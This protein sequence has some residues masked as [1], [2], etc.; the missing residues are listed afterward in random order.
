MDVH[1]GVMLGH[2]YGTEGIVINK[3]LV[4]MKELGYDVIAY[5]DD[6]VVVSDVWEEWRY[7]DRVKSYWK[8]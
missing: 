3:V 2:F 8:N 1:R 4:R 6:L 5:A 7:R